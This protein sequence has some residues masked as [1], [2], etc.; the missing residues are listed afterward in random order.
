MNK[1]NVLYAEDDLDFGR[2][3]KITLESSGFQVELARD[4]EK[5]LE[6][7]RNKRPDLL[8]VDLDLNGQKNGLELIRTIKNDLPS[9]PII[10]YSSHIDP[11]TVITTL[12]MGVMDHIG[13]D[14]DLQVFIA[15]LRNIA[16][17]TYRNNA[18]RMPVYEISDATAFNK[19]NKVLTIHGKEI[20][21]GGKDSRL[22]T[23]LCLHLN[24]WV[25]PRELSIGLWG[26]EKDITNLK[27][28][29]GNLRKLLA[30][31]PAIAIEN[32]NGGYY[33]M[34]NR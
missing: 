28:Y 2:M 8:L 4:A 20:K 22:L 26:I 10:V 7:Y 3:T 19:E 31:D 25:S 32:K 12:D 5:T 17:Q 13:K 1:I 18:V 15:R 9:Y 23:L 11:E 34:E 14:C 29:A 21:L 16:H 6:S 30:P 27:R 33:R 24:E